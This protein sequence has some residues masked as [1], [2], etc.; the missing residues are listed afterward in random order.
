MQ[1]RQRQPRRSLPAVVV[2]C[3]VGMVGLSGGPAAAAEL[4]G[5][6]V[7][8]T[9]GSA[10]GTDGSL[11]LGNLPGARC[12]AGTGDSLFTMEG[13]GLRPYEAF[14]GPGN[15]TGTGPQEFSG[16][17]VANLRTNNPGSFTRS[18][19]Y[20]V[21][22]NCVR[23]PDGAVSD[24][25]ARRLDYTAGGAGSIVIRPGPAAPARPSVDPTPRA[26][27][28]A[29]P[30]GT[31][32]GSTSPG[33]TSPTGAVPAATAGAA[34]LSPTSVPPAAASAG[35]AGP[36]GSGSAGQRSAR[37]VSRA[38]S[39]GLVGGLAV[40]AATAAVLLLLARRR[41]SNGSDGPGTPRPRV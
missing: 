4:G 24:V 33:S 22:F 8:M 6:D 39:P 34:R 32:P 38:A 28:S 37:S 10:S 35:G 21:T 30:G 13:P 18:G 29:S 27:G 9:T 2:A 7:R 15:T 40:L 26:P 17:S 11:F 36:A 12:P 16:A 5:I 41:Q 25:Y 20:V 14:L 23:S 31:S 19:T 1:T 3:A